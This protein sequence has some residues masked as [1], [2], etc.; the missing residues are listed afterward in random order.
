MFF[1]ILPTRGGGGGGGE[2]EST[3]EKQM[4]ILKGV[5]HKGH[6]PCPCLYDCVFSPLCFQEQ[7]LP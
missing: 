7:S 5:I 3:E 4:K 6:Q 2:V 1:N